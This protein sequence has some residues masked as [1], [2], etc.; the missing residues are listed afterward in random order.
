MTTR[1]Q[2]SFVSCLLVAPSDCGTLGFV[3]ALHGGGIAV[4]EREPGHSAL[5]LA[6]S[7]EFHVVA[8]MVD[9]RSAAGPLAVSQ[10]AGA[11]VPVI[12]LHDSAE[13][14]LIADMLSAGAHACLDLGTDARVVSAQVRAVLR[15]A[16][17]YD[18][19]PAEVSGLLQVGDLSVDV[20][21]CEVQR[22]G[23]FV[24]LTASEFRIVEY[25][26][27]HSGRVLKS[28]EVLNAVSSDYEYLPR[29]A[30]DVFKVYVRRIRRKLEPNESEPRYLVTVRGFGYRL[31]GGS[32]IT[33]ALRSAATTA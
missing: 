9:P 27:R 28:H 4:L 19:A 2:S 14:H 10:L 6:L 8:W 32:A 22:A 29:E 21:R 33:P 23:T 30:Q 17:A 5:Q 20:D 15:R 13:A 12:G 16:G 26:A 24:A 11:G 25:M 18:A 31:E 7:G 1:T 3:R